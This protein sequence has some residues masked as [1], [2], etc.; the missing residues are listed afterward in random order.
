V[1]AKPSKAPR[2][3]NISQPPL[4]PPPYPKTKA[5][6]WAQ[7]HPETLERLDGYLDDKSLDLLDFFEP[8]ERIEEVP[9]VFIFVGGIVTAPNSVIGERE[10]SSFGEREDSSFSSLEEGEIQ[11]YPF[12]GDS[13]LVEGVE[14]VIEGYIHPH[15][16]P[17]ESDC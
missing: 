2:T 5:V 6:T 9:A 17:E 3:S 15:I 7:Y 10:D 12:A 16:V 1:T 8:E 11:E 4:R 14:G 13:D